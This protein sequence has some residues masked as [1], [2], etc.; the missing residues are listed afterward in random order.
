MKS[1]RAREAA[2]VDETPINDIAAEAPV[3]K[4]KRSDDDVDADENAVKKA[5][6]KDKKKKDQKESR[7]ER[8]EKRKDLQN[9]PGEEDDDE[10]ADEVEEAVVAEK[11]VEAEVN[12][13]KE[14]K[15]KKKDKKDKKGKKEKKVETNGAAD[16]NSAATN[17]ETSEKKS[18]KNKKQKKD[19]TTEQP[20]TDAEPAAAPATEENGGEDGIDLDADTA[21]KQDRH[22]VFVGNLP[23]T[24]TAATIS[25]HFASL[26]P[27]A[28]R[29]LKNK[30]DDKPCRGIAFVEF[31]K[32]WHMRT[33][34]DKFHHSVFEDGVSPARKINVELTAGGGGKTK[35][36]QDKIRE[37]NKKLEENRF[38]RI[39]KE[40]LAKTE[41]GGSGGG[42]A[43]HNIEDSVH[44]SR[45][46]RV[47]GMN[48]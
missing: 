39:E 3:K 13:K 25:A 23:Y 24:A 37:K 19:T 31:G 44:P 22:I 27:I 48:Y 11:I 1:K 20:T 33:C 47:P 2:E 45:R 10:Q 29:C 34:L 5:S 26:S 42:G 14:K 40:K 15:E 38:K 36:R 46:A 41:N 35:Q 16:E 28:V 21:G 8:K 17:G 4:R 12:G 6:K 18:K 30:G 43:E 7:K 9:L 32:V